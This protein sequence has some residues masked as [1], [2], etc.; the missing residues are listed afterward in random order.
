MRDFAKYKWNG[1]IR[2]WLICTLLSAGAILIG[3]AHV[4]LFCFFPVMF[5]SY[6]AADK[7]VLRGQREG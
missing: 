6:A 2:V 1:S 5:V 3:S 4:F 7:P